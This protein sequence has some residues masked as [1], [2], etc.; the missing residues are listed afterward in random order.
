MPAF[1]LNVRK[2]PSRQ[3]T[4][5]QRCSERT[6]ATTEAFRNKTHRGEDEYMVQE[7]CRLCHLLVKSKPHETEIGCVNVLP[8]TLFLGKNANKVLVWQIMQSS[9]PH[10]EKSQKLAHP[11]CNGRDFWV[12][13]SI[14]NTSRRK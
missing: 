12:K 7:M 1:F 13:I 4:Q 10:A 14:S 5:R 11:E 6:F 9:F 8:K 2:S 3:G